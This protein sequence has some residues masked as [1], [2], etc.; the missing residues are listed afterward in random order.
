MEI[1]NLINPFEITINNNKIELVIKGNVY[2]NHWYLFWG[3][4]QQ[5]IFMSKTDNIVI[6]I[7]ENVYCSTNFILSLNLTLLKCQIKTIAFCVKSKNKYNTFSIENTFELSTLIEK[8]LIHNNQNKDIIQPTICDLKKVE[9]I[10]EYIAKIIRNM[11]NLDSCFSD[12]KS[13]NEF[14]VKLQN[15]LFELMDNSYKYAYENSPNCYIA[16]SVKYTNVDTNTWQKY[17]AINN[18]SFAKE[19]FISPK[20]VLYFQDL[21]KGIIDS[22]I[23]TYGIKKSSKRPLREVAKKAFFYNADFIARKNTT[24]ICGLQYV[25]KI[26]EHN[27]SYLTVYSGKE[28][29]GTHFAN[30]EKNLH[31]AF[32]I[33]DYGLSTHTQGLSYNFFIDIEQA[34]SN[35]HDN[36]FDDSVIE[37]L[38][39]NKKTQ[40]N[41]RDF[42]NIIETNSFGEICNPF[43]NGQKIINENLKCSFIFLGRAISKQSIV[44]ILKNSIQ[45]KTKT[46]IICDVLDIDMQLIVFSLK[47]SYS[48][49]LGA[50]LD[51]IYIVSQTLN[52]IKLKS[53]NGR[54]ITDKFEGFSH[55]NK[56]YDY[57]YNIKYYESFVLLSLQECDS[58]GKHMITNG[59]I[60]WNENYS[61][62]GYINFDILTASPKTFNFLKLNLV[63]TLSLLGFPKLIPLD[64]MVNRLADEINSEYNLNEKDDTL[65][66]GS[67]YVSGTTYNYNSINNEKNLHFFN[68]NKDEKVLSIFISPEKAL[69][70]NSNKTEYKRIGKSYKIIKMEELNKEIHSGAYLSQKEKYSLFDTDSYNPFIFKH[71]TFYGNHYMLNINLI[72]MYNDKSSL[73]FDFITKLINSS[74]GHY[75]DLGIHNE[76]YFQ[77]FQNCCGIIY[78]SHHF[79]DKIFED[80]IT[81]N[82][83]LAKY[84]I[85]LNHINLFRYEQSLEFSHVYAEYINELKNEFKKNFPKEEIKFIIFD[86]LINSGRTRK[87]IKLYLQSLGVERVIFVSIIDSQEQRYDKS[88][89]NYSFINVPFPRIGSNSSCPICEN[90]ETQKVFLRN[91]VSPNLSYKLDRICRYMKCSD[92][93]VSRGQI[94][95]FSISEVVSKDIIQENSQYL[96]CSDIS[97]KKVLTLYLFISEQIRQLND[98]WLFDNFLEN[99]FKDL[100]IDSAVLILSL[101]YLDFYN[102]CY[103]KL[104]EKVTAI[105][106]KLIGKVTDEKIF[107]L[108]Y[109]VLTKHKQS[110]INIIKKIDF[111]ELYFSENVEL[112]LLYLFCYPGGDTFVHE[113]NMKLAIM[114]NN[115]IIG[116][117]HK[118]DAYKQLHCQLIN[119]NGEIHNSP[120]ENVITFKN[121][122]NNH[123]VKTA[124]NSLELLKTSLKTDTIRFDVFYDNDEYKLENYNELLDLVNEIVDMKNHAF[125]D[126]FEEKIIQLYKYAR[127]IHSYLLLPLGIAEKTKYNSTLIYKLKQIVDQFNEESGGKIVKFL[128]N[129]TLPYSNYG[130]KELYYIF[131]S[132]LVNEIRYCLDN[133]KKHCSDN[134]E[135]YLVEEADNQ[136]YEYLG[137][138]GLDLSEEK[139]IID[140]VNGISENYKPRNLK[141]R[142]QKEELKNLG[143]TIERIDS[144]LSKYSAC[145]NKQSFVTR[146]TI[147]NINFI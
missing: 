103:I 79:T 117:N 18:K 104:K 144:N 16:F 113:K 107:A 130:A 123:Y 125:D 4:I 110:T 112:L 5:K 44:Y 91:I 17:N 34:I 147:P 71:T 133:I 50:K 136:M 55:F 115:S 86:T 116:N 121:K 114:L 31:T 129:Y 101:F 102:Q 65:Y 84:I 54:F 53:Y 62:S 25:G 138:V 23:N 143:I 118:I 39:C 78:I 58:F 68:R 42:R 99:K 109:F 95:N 120:I 56:E 142:Y 6:V 14:K 1:L 122:N 32:S 89:N 124:I 36:C 59:T 69:A 90:I 21:G 49:I 106:L 2:D 46:L 119:V 47:D 100:D 93:I 70:H 33:S 27:H 131:N 83:N 85:G 88:K 87:E 77:E 67:I 92:L 74:L 10:N 64:N 43:I 7:E 128:N 98:F 82:K 139:I 80:Q 30:V 127:E 146:I 41:V 28:C 105:L 48:T 60:V 145:F 96:V 20:I 19:V 37:S 108:S 51:N 132:I 72:S 57:I 94:G 13:E 137:V 9:T 15:I 75:F 3:T 81:Q 29:V 40:I 61:F 26:L 126:V 66:L 141:L 24:N 135:K 8:Y 22:Y 140:I 63:R 76:E 111:D 73:L 35:T 52:V 12:E 134:N 45:D 38:M 11:K 97:I